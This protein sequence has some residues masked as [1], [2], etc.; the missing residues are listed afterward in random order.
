MRKPPIGGPSAVVTADA[1]AQV[2][3][4]LPRMSLGKV[5]EMIARLC[6][7]RSAAPTP[8]IA[9]AAISS[10]ALGATAHIER[11]DGEDDDAGQEDA[12]AAD[13]VAE[14]A[15][16][17]DQSAPASADRRWPPTASPR[18]RRRGPSGSQARRCRPR[19]SR[20][21][22]WPRRWSWPP[23]RSAAPRPERAGAPAATAACLP[24]GANGSWV[25]PASSRSPAPPQA[26]RQIRIFLRQR[27]TGTSRSE[28]PA[29]STVIA[30]ALPVIH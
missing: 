17:E 3:I 5:A 7:T 29:Q 15:A 12:A 24:S 16:G 6:G 2:P 1:A 21:R 25:M 18:C 30:M 27:G 14:P 13:A 26:R 23:G 4:A 8:W 11:G 9:R 19:S 28:T 22:P 20:R 10:A